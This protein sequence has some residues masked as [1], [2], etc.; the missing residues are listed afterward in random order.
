VPRNNL[1]SALLVVLPPGNYTAMVSSAS[2]TGVALLEVADLRT[3][4][5]STI[6]NAVSSAATPARAGALA[7]VAELCDTLPLA[8]AG[9]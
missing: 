4:A 2:G 6:A 8:V 3:L 7:A 1:E 9:R 5:P